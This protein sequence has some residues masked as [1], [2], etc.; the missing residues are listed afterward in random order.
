MSEDET[1]D[2]NRTYHVTMMFVLIAAIVTCGWA[3][4]CAGR[5]H[6]DCEHESE[7]PDADTTDTDT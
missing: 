3:P 4:S 1:S 7:E 6:T 2:P 5:A